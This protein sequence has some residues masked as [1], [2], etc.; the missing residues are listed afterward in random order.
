MTEP[1]SVRAWPAPYRAEP[2]DA[3]ASLPGSKSLTNR[4]LVLAA[5]SDAPSHIG[6]PLRARDTELMASALRSLGTTIEE[7]GDGWYVE[8]GPLRG[9]AQV[10]C[11]LA[12]TVMR[13]VPPVAALATGEVAFD[14]DP[15]ARERPMSTV[16]AALRHL[17]ADINDGGRGALPFTVRGTGTV[18]GGVVTIDASAS[19]QFV[20]ALLLSGPRYRDGVDVRHSGKPVP[21][22]PHIDMTITQLRAR[23]IEV[24][25]AE[26]NRWVVRPGTVKAVDARVEP[27][28]SNAGPF[29]AAALVTGGR[30]RI[31]D[32]PET[33]DQAGDR[34]REIAALMGATVS[35]DGSD[36]VVE[37]AA[38][39]EGVDVDLHD[40]GELT[41]VVAAVCALAASPSRLRG[42]GHLRG[43]ETDRL[44]AI[45]SEINALGGEVTEHEDGLEIRP[46]PLHGGRFATYDD[47]RIAHA[48]VVL[49]LAVD[50]VQVE[51]IAT[52]SKTYPDFPAQW[53][54]FVR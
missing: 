19:S 36:L 5:L 41:P 6:V 51:N 18:P 54:R 24:D 7:S 31:T 52:T 32:W 29:I 14:G 8:P 53:E 22:M 2:I 16:L 33:T 38:T 21:S 13:F 37:C 15:Y 43:H 45:A 20:S 26:P 12:G 44:A 50:G 46:T 1:E 40:V 47:H 28:L 42:I 3:T 10:D 11:G 49:G 30:V 23:G 34:W 48:G 4:V 17:G 27:D 25:D 35:Q 39:L 9:P